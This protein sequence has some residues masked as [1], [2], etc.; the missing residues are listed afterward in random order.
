MREYRITVD[1]G[2][3]KDVLEE[4]INAGAEF[5]SVALKDGDG[6]LVEWGDHLV[7]AKDD[8]DDAEPYCCEK[9]I[10]Q[11]VECEPKNAT[12]LMFVNEHHPCIDIIY[13][14]LYKINEYNTNFVYILN[15]SGNTQVIYLYTG[16]TGV[17]YLRK[18]VSNN[19]ENP[20]CNCNH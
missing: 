17:K 18:Q 8:D 16:W 19:E 3:L 1:S 15:N 13:D 9:T 4:L 12:H 14:K 11:Y 20:C 10:E 6:Y 2:Y 7:A 5:P